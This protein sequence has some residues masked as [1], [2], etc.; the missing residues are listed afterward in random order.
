MHT[1]YAC[2]K[3]FDV[4]LLMDN[5]QVVQ[6]ACTRERARLQAEELRRI[7]RAAYRERRQ[8]QRSREPQ[9]VYIQTAPGW[10]YGLCL[11]VGAL[12]GAWVVAVI[13]L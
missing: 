5:D 4:G 10:Q 1:R 9:V 11:F 8:Q 7:V 12:F 6:C 2:Q 3:C 13:A